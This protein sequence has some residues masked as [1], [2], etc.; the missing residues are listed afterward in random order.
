VEHVNRNQTPVVV[1]QSGE[2]K[3][4]ILAVESYQK[5]INAINLA[6][7]INLAE[8]DIEKGRVISHKEAKKYFK[9]ILNRK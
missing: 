8:K 7:L 9:K 4:V 6:K 3:A 1:T 2:A 5:L